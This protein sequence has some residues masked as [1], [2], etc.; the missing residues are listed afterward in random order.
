[1]SDRGAIPSCCAGLYELEITRVLL[2][3]SLHPGGAALTRRL[4]A[5]AL[6]HPGSLV[7]DV[8]SGRGRSL[9]VWAE[10]F[11]SR[12]VGVDYSA[13]NLRAARELIPSD[14]LHWSRGEA[15]ALPFA[16]DTFD[17]VLCECALCTFPDMNGAVT[18][19]LRVLRPGG[20]VGISD[21]VLEAPVPEALQGLFG[22]VLCIAGARSRRGYLETLVGAGFEAVR[23]EDH[24][25]ALLQMVADIEGRL[26]TARTLAE[27]GELDLPSEL[28]DDVELLG[29]ARDFVR[30]GGVGYALFSARKQR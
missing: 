3:P 15:G 16:A 10:Q 19:M 30:S 18:E 9:A 4:G 28:L 8:A 5:A 6:L 17:A 27:A 23:H 13:Q 14:R 20:R 22:R 24:S 11:G 7:L 29:T 2:G 12:G 21:M 1:M 26:G 25:S